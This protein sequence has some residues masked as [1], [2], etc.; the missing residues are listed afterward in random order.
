MPAHHGF[1]TNDHEMILS[2]WPEPG[3]RDPEG[4]IHGSQP[5]PRAFQGIR[6]KLL[7]QRQLYDRL[8][9]MTSEEGEGAVEEQRRETD[10]SAHGDRDPA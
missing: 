10:Q 5:R 7:S 4:A 9:S 8:L 3:E 6:S 2:A 1:G